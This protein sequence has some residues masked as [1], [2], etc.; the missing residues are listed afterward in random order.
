MMSGLLFFSI[1]TP[2]ISDCCESGVAIFNNGRMLKDWNSTAIS[3]IPTVV[4]PNTM[5]DFRPISCCSVIYKCIAKG[6][7][8]LKEVL[9]SLVGQQQSTFVAGRDIV[10][11]VLLMQEVLENYHKEGGTP[12]CAFKS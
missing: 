1:L 4:L 9:P 7:N 6:D 11:N 5:K 8:A 10:D 12:S 3:L 2:G